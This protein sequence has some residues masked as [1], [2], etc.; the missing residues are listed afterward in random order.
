MNSGYVYML[1]N[2]RMTVLYTGSTND[3]RRRLYHH[4][5]RLVPG[6]SK[7]YN[8]HRLV[9]FEIQPDM[10]AAR[11]REQQIKGLSRAKK[12]AMVIAANPERRDLIEDIPQDASG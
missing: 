6:F 9:Y 10:N 7:K 12:D 8:A 2:D 1:M 4:R 5:N 3:L 11:H